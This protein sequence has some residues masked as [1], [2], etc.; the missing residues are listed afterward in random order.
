MSTF[1]ITDSIQ[2]RDESDDVERYKRNSA[3]LSS[4]L[5]Q[6]NVMYEPNHKHFH[7]VTQPQSTKHHTGPHTCRCGHLTTMNG[8]RCLRWLPK[9]NKS[10]L[11]GCGLHYSS[12]G[13]NGV[14]VMLDGQAGSSKPWLGVL[15]IIAILLTIVPR[16]IYDGAD[17]LRPKP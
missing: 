6:Y 10:L 16:Q 4:R 1:A 7:S 2:S 12:D 13:P 8:S 15:P 9:R 11:E 17:V 14:F 5:V 3:S